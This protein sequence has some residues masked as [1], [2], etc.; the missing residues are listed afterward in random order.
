MQS[1]TDSSTQLVASYTVNFLKQ[2]IECLIHHYTIQHMHSPRFPVF[3][4]LLAREVGRRSKEEKIGDWRPEGRCWRIQ[5]SLNTAWALWG[6]PRVCLGGREEGGD[7]RLV[8]HSFQNSS[9]L[10]SLAY[11]I[12]NMSCCSSW[13]VTVTCTWTFFERDTSPYPQS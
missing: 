6:E 4:I 5:E 2:S 7:I 1:K 8:Q 9:S 12:S 11:P 3:L 10:A 13:R